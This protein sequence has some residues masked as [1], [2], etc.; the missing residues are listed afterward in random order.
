MAGSCAKPMEPTKHVRSA[1]TWP[2]TVK[3]KGG[4]HEDMMKKNTY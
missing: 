4:V 1:L 3:G 2:K